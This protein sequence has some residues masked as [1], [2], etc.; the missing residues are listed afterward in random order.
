M[1]LKI[2]KQQQNN[3]K[4]LKQHS[5]KS[6]NDHFQSSTPKERHAI[7]KPRQTL[8]SSTIRCKHT[9]LLREHLGRSNQMANNGYVL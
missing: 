1:T 8:S 3:K 5:H 2:Q 9:T 6:Q 7:T 4:G